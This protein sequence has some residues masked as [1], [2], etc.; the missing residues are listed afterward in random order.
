MPEWEDCAKTH[1]GCGGVVRWVEAVE[2]PGVGYYGECLLCGREELVIED[3][4]PIEKLD[5]QDALNADPEDLEDFYW[6]YDALWE[7]NQKRLLEKLA[8]D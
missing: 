8:D 4:I 3:I 6:D 5:P 7:E 1:E 2:T